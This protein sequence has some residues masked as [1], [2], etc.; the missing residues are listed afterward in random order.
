[1]VNWINYIAFE[2]VRFQFTASKEHVTYPHVFSNYICENTKFHKYNDVKYKKCIMFGLWQFN[3]PQLISTAGG[4]R[5]RWWWTWE[6]PPICLPDY[7]HAVANPLSP[8]ALFAWCLRGWLHL[9]ACERRYIDSKSRY[10][11]RPT[12][13]SHYFIYTRRGV[14]AVRN[15]HKE[16]RRSR[17]RSPNAIIAPTALT[18]APGQMTLRFRR[19]VPPIGSSPHMNITHQ[20]AYA[21]KHLQECIQCRREEGWIDGAENGT[22]L[23]DVQRDLSCP[24]IIHWLLFYYFGLHLGWLLLVALHWYKNSPPPIIALD[25]YCHWNHFSVSALSFSAGDASGRVRRRQTRAC[26]PL[27]GFIYANY[28]APLLT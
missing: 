6:S 2:K 12:R 10:S 9:R 22:L 11:A 26:A 20:S 23:R 8:S 3:F 7:T 13:L 1:M 19:L 21:S 28:F 14:R 17:A 24:T 4:G 25:L 5:W 15:T 18:R 16:R 27:S